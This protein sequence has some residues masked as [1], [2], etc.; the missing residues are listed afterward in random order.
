MSHCTGSLFSPPLTYI[1]V[2]YLFE[3]KSASVSQTGLKRLSQLPGFRDHRHDSSHLACN[4][5]SFFFFFF[6]GVSRLV[7]NSQRSTCLSLQKSEIKGVHH[8]AQP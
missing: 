5:L 1:L 4:I 6:F 2:Y 3:I 7:L 8:Y